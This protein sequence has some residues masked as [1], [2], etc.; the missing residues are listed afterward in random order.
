MP[1]PSPLRIASP[2]AWST[3]L[4]MVSSSTASSRS[5]AAGRSSRTTISRPLLRKA[6]SRKR[7]VIVSKEYV[8]V[9][10]ISSEAQ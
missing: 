6:Y 1:P 4:S 8:V 7:L 2:P 5:S 3:A 10:K 9:S